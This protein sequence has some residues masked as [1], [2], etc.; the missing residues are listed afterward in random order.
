MASA[1]GICGLLVKGGCRSVHIGGGEPFLDFEG[2]LM[3]VRALRSAGIRLEY[4]E[5]NGFFAQGGKAGEYLHRLLDEGV[6]TLCISL[7]PYHAEHVPYGAPLELAR[8]CGETGMGFFL[9]KEEYL[10]Q[11]S[12]LSP[13]KAHS[14]QEMEN[15]IC[16][17]YIGRTAVSYGIGYGGRAVN[18]ENEFAAAPARP[19][20]EFAQDKSPCT[21]LL[22]SGHFHVDMDGFFIPPHCTG[23]RIPLS[24]A[25]FG[26]PEGSYPVFRALYNGGISAL[27]DFALRQG[28]SP[29][30]CGYLSKCSLCFFARSFLCGKGFDELDSDHYAEALKYY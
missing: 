12:G 29:D 17:D 30:P 3:T 4:I 5:T 15:A 23:I 22:S 6:D 16:S 21:N 24:E 14:R 11:L 20:E 2:L 27:L 10:R 1:A 13:Q 28:F 7:D 26:I 8:L 18:I 19:A 25:A 9:W